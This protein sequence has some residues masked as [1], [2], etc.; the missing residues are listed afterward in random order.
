MAGPQGLLPYPFF[1][2]KRQHLCPRKPE[3]VICG[4]NFKQFLCQE[5]M[6]MN[7]RKQQNLLFTEGPILGPLLSYALPELLA[8]L[9]QAQ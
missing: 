4:S 5:V 3:A 6:I 2:L 9:L 8:L 7:K 1:C